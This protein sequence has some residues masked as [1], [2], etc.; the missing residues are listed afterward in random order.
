[1]KF[2]L[3]IGLLY[4]NIHV[5]LL[6]IYSQAGNYV[7]NPIAL[8]SLSMKFIALNSVYVHQSITDAHV[9]AQYKCSSLF[10]DTT[11]HNI[12]HIRS[13]RSGITLQLFSR[14]SKMLAVCRPPSPAPPAHRRA[15][16]LIQNSLKQRQLYYLVANV[17]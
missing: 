2:I 13:T 12:K 17:F 16:P 4:L 8:R 5:Y 10:Y 9:K 6:R 1:M 11:I 3:L 14:P 15:A 7:N